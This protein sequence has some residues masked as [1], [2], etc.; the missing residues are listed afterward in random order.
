M[1]A[2]VGVG[3]GLA[4]IASSAIWLVLGN[5]SAN[6]GETASLTLE[7]AVGPDTAGLSV[8]AKF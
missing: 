8:G 2:N 1:I 3:L 7:P 5:S 4:V 6:G